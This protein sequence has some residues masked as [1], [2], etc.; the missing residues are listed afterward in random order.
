MTVSEFIEQLKMF[1]S[2]LLVGY[3]SAEY[4]TFFEFNEIYQSDKR[5]VI[6]T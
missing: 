2:D 5:K 4:E 3:Y 1:D 6:I